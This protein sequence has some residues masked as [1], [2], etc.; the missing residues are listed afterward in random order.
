MHE[1]EQVIGSPLCL[2]RERC[3]PL[4][5]GE[6]C[7]AEF[8]DVVDPRETPH[9]LL[10]SQLLQ[11][12][13]VQVSHARVPAPGHVVVAHRHA[14]GLRWLD[15]EYVEAVAVALHL[16]EELASSVE[17]TQLPV[18]DRDP[19]ADLV[20]LPEAH[21]VGAQAGYEVHP[22]ERALAPVLAREQHRAASA[23]VHRGPVPKAHVPAHAGVQL[24]EE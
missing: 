12:L 8:V 18:L 11:R 21:Y 5:A 16:G 10:S 6:A 22:G 1:I 19:A 14:L 7:V 20:Q 17:H 23:D 13:E 4:L 3:P 15:V 2:L 24:G 9:H